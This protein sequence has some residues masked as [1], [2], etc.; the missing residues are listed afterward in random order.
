MTDENPDRYQSPNWLTVDQLEDGNLRRDHRH[1]SAW[2]LSE[3]DA[4]NLELSD[5]LWIGGVV[6]ACA[7]VTGLIVAWGWL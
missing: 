5:W 1:G 3:P 6:A 7:V 4:G 2:R